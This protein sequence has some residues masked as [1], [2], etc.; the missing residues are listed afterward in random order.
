MKKCLVSY[1][2]LGF[3]LVALPLLSGCTQQNPF[4]SS[5]R[6]EVITAEPGTNASIASAEV[7]TNLVA[8]TN[9]PAVAQTNAPA[10]IPT[11]VVAEAEG[12]A[13]PLPPTEQKPPPDLQLSP[14]LSEAVKLVQSGVG[15]SVLF[16][17]ITNTTG[18][19]SLGADEIVYLNDLGVEG[20]VITAMMEHDKELRELRAN[21][22]AAYAASNQAT[23]QVAQPE[24]PDDEMAAAPSYVE[25]PPMEAEPVYVSN[26]YFYDT[27]SPYG[28][29]VYVPGYGSCWRPTAAYSNPGWRPY[30]DRGRWVYSD[31]GW[32]WVSDYTWGATTFHYGRWFN[33]SRYGWC[34]WPD[35]VWAPSWVSWRYTS[36]YCGWAPLPPNCYYQSGFGL[37]YNSGSVGVSFGFGLGYN[38]YAFVPWGTFCSPKPYKHCLPGSSAVHVYNNSKPYN[39][40]E[41]GGQGKAHNRG[42]AP[43]RVRELS[44]TE[45]RT[46]TVQEQTGRSR[47]AERIER[48]GTTLTVRR[49]QFTPTTPTDVAASG[50]S[51]P[52]SR[53]ASTRS[54][55]PSVSPTV[56]QPST[57][58]TSTLSPS[59]TRVAP[60]PDAKGQNDRLFVTRPARPT[61]P[62][63]S[64]G[65]S[66]VEPKPPVTPPTRAEDRTERKVET[67]TANR[68]RAASPVVVRPTQQPVARPVQPQTVT[69]QVSTTTESGSRENTTSQPRVI[70]PNRQTPSR[71][72]TPASRSSIVV[73]GN[74]NNNR[75]S[76]RDYSVWSTPS[77]SP[78]QNS[79]R[80]SVSPR[81]AQPTQPSTVNTPQVA[82]TSPA[83]VSRAQN[84]NW[85]NRGNDNNRGNNQTYSV[86]QAGQV[87]G[88]STRTAPAA[89]YNARPAQPAPGQSYT[90]RSQP[91]AQPGAARVESRPAPAPAPAQSR[92]SAPANSQPSQNQGRP[93]R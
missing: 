74:G 12:A 87:I 33:D 38:S 30:V 90:P 21:A 59:T 26:T 51:R 65:N 48:D 88:P 79:T 85:Q 32:Y 75:S 69:P 27:L 54:S 40:W 17:F 11:N 41:G 68:S 56:Q 4:V 34:W 78:A 15:Q 23:Q 91:S 92:P 81:N 43:A 53:P 76:G 82:E 35:T 61:A 67:E 7:V 8:D 31:C 19:F 25:P 37:V 50:T 44:R 42:L 20:E 22:W 5:A 3:S 89:N 86:P 70:Q 6:A 16:N 80:E 45:V 71:S 84:G 52:N 13:A 1:V 49:P 83:L 55:D 60:T 36:D 39:H 14:V 9:A 28:S 58:L 64:T 93:S 46:V 10:A 47:R 57:P 63:T 18:Y 2:A 29:W 24:Q 66:T 73:I 72:T 62:V 77:P